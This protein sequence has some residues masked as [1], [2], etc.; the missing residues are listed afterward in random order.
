MTRASRRSV[1][2]RQDV[3]GRILEPSDSHLA[4]SV[5][6]ALAGE[7]GQIVLLEG[8]TPALQLLRRSFHVIHFPQRGRS[9]VRPGELRTD[10]TVRAASAAVRSGDTRLAADARESQRVFV[11]PGRGVEVLHREHGLYGC[12]SQHAGLLA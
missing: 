6:V 11:E 2:D 8:D 5:D 9:L 3:A 12:V 4:C 1:L 7:A 10:D